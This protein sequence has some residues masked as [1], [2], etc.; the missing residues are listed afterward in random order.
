VQPQTAHRYQSSSVADFEQAREPIRVALLATLSRLL[1]NSAVAQIPT[2]SQIQGW[3]V[4]HLVNAADHW[5]RMAD[6]WDT[7]FSE[8]HQ[9]VHAVSWQG[10]G[11]DAARDRVTA[12][13]AVA[14][15]TSDQL[16]E[17]ARIARSGAGYIT[18]AHSRVRY[19]VEDA[20]QAKF[21]VHEDLSVTDKLNV[22]SSA[23]RAARRAQAQTFAADIQRRAS[24]LAEL[25]NQVGVNITR[26]AEGV[27]ADVFG[28][29]GRIQAVNSEVCNDPDYTKG[30]ERR[31]WGSAIAVPR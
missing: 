25:D 13:R 7:A 19:A 20:Q 21:N 16:R 30:I 23:Q 15:G 14:S 22:R 3:S 9:Q 18:A 6:H 2:L 24:E 5:T 28:N 31:L 27:G 8:V 10:V 26:A 1:D 12:D 11:A 29:R 4:E 17:A